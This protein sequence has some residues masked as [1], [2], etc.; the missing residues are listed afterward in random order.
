MRTPVFDM[1][2]VNFATN[3]VMRPFGAA[4]AKPRPVQP[5]NVLPPK[6]MMPKA[7]PP[8]GG[9]KLIP[10]ASPAFPYPTGNP[11]TDRKLGFH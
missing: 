5:P 2:F 1:N 3:Q 6:F 7:Q 11:Y 8:V 4:K 10:R 9:V